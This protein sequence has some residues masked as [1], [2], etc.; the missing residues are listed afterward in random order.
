M[1]CVDSQTW[2][3]LAEGR[4][5]ADE[6]LAIREHAATCA[7]CAPRLAEID[8]KKRLAREAPTMELSATQLPRPIEPA[9]VLER[10]AQVGRF[11]ILETLGM[12][13]MGAVY[14]AYD[15]NLDRKVALKTL[16]FSTTG[17]P[18]A[19]GRMLREAQ[20]MARLSHP[21]VVNV[22]EVGENRGAIFIA[23]ELV[24]GVTLR[25]WERAKE[26]TWKEVV[27]VFLQAGQGLAAA[28]AAHLVHRDFKPANVLLGDDGR[29]RVTDF[30][31]AR[32]DGTI[33]PVGPMPQAQG[34]DSGRFGNGPGT[35]GTAS[36]AHSGSL[37]DPLTR[38]DVVVGTVGYMSPEQAAA[39]IPDAR[40]DQ[41]AFCICLWEALYGKRPFQGNS[42]AE[43]TKALLEGSLPQRPRTTKVPT[44]L[45]AVM[46]RG[47]ERDPEKRYP[48]M[49][50]LL[51]EL[52]R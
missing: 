37:S 7:T 49:E 42:V 26:R 48:S 51:K 34:E 5:S 47:L 13:G 45:H 50:A 46:T 27:R 38:G 15:P 36:T 16:H 24:A 9:P 14:S 52:D 40:S 35:G 8:Q 28:H 2:S 44:W 17:D 6:E 11:V 43:T 25:T 20:A 32:A 30:G 1:P 18:T 4:L 3:A 41:F 12:G 29:V 21:N 39:K 33:E 23:M 22:F 19:H 10:G 31:V